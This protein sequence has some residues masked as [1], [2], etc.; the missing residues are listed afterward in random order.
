MIQWGCCDSAVPD[1]VGQ[2][3]DDARHHS[4]LRGA[5]LVHR[6]QERKEEEVGGTRQRLLA[7]SEGVAVRDGRY[8]DASSGGSSRETWTMDEFEFYGA[9]ERTRR[10]DSCMNARAKRQGSDLNWENHQKLSG[11]NTTQRISGFGVGVSTV[12]LDIC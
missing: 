2:T 12:L 9:N 10:V 7:E 6:R 11:T 8:R 5:A 3:A 1:S 4:G